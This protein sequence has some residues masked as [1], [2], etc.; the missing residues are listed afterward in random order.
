MWVG[1][2]FPRSPRP[3][4]R[5]AVTVF[6]NLMRE[7]RLRQLA[8][9]L[10]LA[11]WPV[12]ATFAQTESNGQPPVAE[13]KVDDAVKRS[14]PSSNSEKAPTD[15]KT[16]KS[17][18]SNGDT[19]RLP[20]GR[21]FE[22]FLDFL[23][24]EGPDYAIN[25]VELTG[26]ADGD[27]A[28]LTATIL[29]QVLRDDEWLRVPLFLNEAV[30]RKTKYKYLGT[31]PG[32]TDT[33]ATGGRAAYGDST[34]EAGYRW[35]FRERGHHKLTLT[36]IVPVV[37][38]VAQ[39]RM[40]LTLPPLV[41]A[42]TLSLKVP[43]AGLEKS[44]VA[45]PRDSDLRV[46]KSGKKHSEIEITGIGTQLDVQWRSVTVKPS[47]RPL[48]RSESAMLVNVTEDTVVL[49]VLQKIGAFSGKFE[50]VGVT[51]PPG[52]RPLSVEGKFIE[53]HTPPDA[54]NR[55]V[56][57]FSEARSE[58]TEIEWTL[59]K[60]F[61]PRTGR[62]SLEGFGI[63]D[64]RVQTGDIAL[65]KVPGRR[66]SKLDD[67]NRAVHR[68]R[69]ADFRAAD[70]IR[71][72]SLYG[73]FRFIKQPFRLNLD[74][75]PL[76]SHVTVD[77]QMTLTFSKDRVTLNAKFLVN[78]SEEGGL[79][80]RLEVAWPGWKDD[81]WK[82]Q[83]QAASGI[84][85]QR[86][87]RGKGSGLTYR[88]FRRRN[89]GFPVQ[90]VASRPIPKEGISSL[91]L[92][93]MEAD[94]TQ[95]TALTVRQ[96]PNIEVLLSQ[97]GSVLRPEADESPKPSTQ[98]R[99]FRLVSATA[100]ISAEVT[101]H[102]RRV[103]VRSNLTLFPSNG[104]VRVRQAIE[105]DVRYEPLKSVAVRV[106]AEFAKL[107][108]FV[109]PNG[110]ILDAR[111]SGLPAEDERTVA[112]VIPA[113]P[114]TYGRHAFFAEY[115]VRF[116]EN[117]ER[118][119]SVDVSLPVV[120][121]PEAQKSQVRLQL[122]NDSSLQLRID[123]PAW[124]PLLLARTTGWIRDDA[125]SA[126]EVSLSDPA[127]PTS[128][129]FVVSRALLR[130][131]VAPGGGIRYRAQ[132]R[133]SQGAGEFVFFLPRSIRTDA[134][135]IGKHRLARPLG[136]Q[137]LEHRV[138][139]RLPIED[140]GALLT[141]DYHADGGSR[142][143]WISGRTLIAPTFPPGVS[144]GESAWEAVLP[145]G[146]HIAS[147][148]TTAFAE[149]EWEFDGRVFAR[150][151]T[152]A[153][154]RSGEWIGESDGPEWKVPSNANAYYFRQLGPSRDLPI[155]TMSTSAIVL[156]GA[157]LAWLIGLMLARF[158]AARSVYTFLTLGL[159]ASIVGLWY[160]HELQ[161]LAQPAALGAALAVACVGIEHLLKRNV[162]TP[163]VPAA[164]PT[165][166]LLNS[167]ATMSTSGHRSIAIG[168][169]EVTDHNVPESEPVPASSEMWSSG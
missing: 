29:V 51:L 104:G 142:L 43:V 50:Q 79:I 26:S 65:L 16:T 30:I 128:R 59:E 40:R 73:A 106:P 83:P 1:F 108:Q 3:R 150:Q 41:A 102:P 72:R 122:A 54:K 48:L 165:E 75:A 100:P 123:D 161:L 134:I 88:L 67:G 110:A 89:G 7:F 56:V 133:L 168:S 151:P 118:G 112:L 93:R 15:G 70:F 11:L 120:L 147:H 13:E 82:L 14:Q 10:L 114:T 57:R 35:W 21:E 117:L 95:P 164:K 23:K 107:V 4:C 61:N 158:S 132:Y 156:F 99:Q 116:Q 148:G 45:A 69:P 137:L 27:R 33:K 169:E 131:V 86:V 97:N 135:W 115:F 53:S 25:S 31:E 127:V 125:P 130:A 49:S 84:I 28:V 24:R 160:P 124:R 62:L 81:G 92:P 46:H 119:G 76:E 60:K 149:Y 74:V 146:H 44:Q 155:G 103:E 129:Q 152:G 105:Y 5:F 36:I 85:E 52:F 34:R 166:F 19:I 38:T 145:A 39:R 121:L 80:D 18:P 157:G 113:L 78:V 98:T 2:A 138:A 6:P 109:G 64:A 68:I 94:V 55:T 37:R 126:I 101:I 87:P 63:D 162:R 8:A 143:D 66:I 91:R 42:S 159:L 141:I 154:R 20:A 153:F 163:N 96:E 136:G 22:Q 140:R 12:A 71:D 77:P 111:L 47:S 139:Y 90:L 144:V 58:P 9:L 167:R 17:T 32:G